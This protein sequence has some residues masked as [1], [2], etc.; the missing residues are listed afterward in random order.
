MIIIS[1]FH[2]FLPYLSAQIYGCWKKCLI[3]GVYYLLRMRAVISE[4]L[5]LG[6]HSAVG[7]FAN[8]AAS[9]EPILQDVFQLYLHGDRVRRMWY[10]FSYYK[11][12]DYN[13]RSC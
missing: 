13:M 9:K 4:C 5:D 12:I 1:S 11:Q 10:I 2:S 3:L 7:L 8:Y 6:M